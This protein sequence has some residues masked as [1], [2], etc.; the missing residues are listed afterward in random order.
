MK[1][2]TTILVFVFL[3]VSN[4]WAQ[5][6]MNGTFYI[7]AAGTKPGGGD[8]E[9]T[10][11]KA[12]V[13]ALNTNGV[14]GA[15]TFYFTSTD[16]TEPADITLG[17]AG[18]SSTNTVTFKPYT[19]VTGVKITFTTEGNTGAAGSIDG[20]F[21]IGSPTGVNTNLVP[22]NYVTIDGSNAADGTTKDLS[23]IGPATAI[24]KSV[25]RIF[26]NNDNITIK[27]C[28]ITCN[29]TSA[30]MAAALNVSNFAPSSA[31]DYLTVSNCTLNSTAGNGG[32]AMYL[33]NSGSPTVGAKGYVISNN[34]LN[35]RQRG[36]YIL[37]VSEGEISGN[38]F[39]INST[40]AAQSAVGLFFISTMADAGV[41][42]IYN[43]NF[44]SLTTQN[45]TA[46]NVNGIIGIDIQSQDPKVFNIYNNMISGLGTTAATA[47]AKLYGIRVTSMA[48]ANI[49]NNTIYIPEM[50]DMTLFGASFIA[51]ITYAALSEVAPKAGGAVNLK[52]NLIICDETV[53]KV[54]GIR[55]AGT[56]GTFTSNHN[57]IF[58]NPANTSSFTGHFNTTSHQT[59]DAW[60]AASLQDSASVAVAVNFVS[61]SDVHLA[62]SSIGDKNLT[63]VPVSFITKD[64]DGDLRNPLF[65]YMGADENTTAPLPVEL[66]SFS[67]ST[68]GLNVVL[69][70]KTATELNSQFFEPERRSG[71][72]AWVKAGRVSASGNSST[73]RIYTFADRLPAPGSYSYRLKM[74]DLDG[75]FSYSSVVNV[76]SGL[77]ENYSLSQNYPNPFNPSTTISYQLPQDG[78]V[79]LSVFDALGREVR[80]LVNTFQQ[81]G[82]HS[83]SVDAGSLT[84]GIYFYRLTVNNVTLTK[85]MQLM[86]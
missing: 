82:T 42:N 72:G 63:A 32:A 18:T 85:K 25:I 4:V 40:A 70:W 52:N 41:F 66:T 62:G 56:D 43:N 50:T 68:E 26:G 28:I 61:P 47:N 7:G 11:L 60:K 64:F 49:F 79:R 35:A 80:S 86:K 55:R 23:I 53:M 27:N 36:I 71:N 24:Q 45:T 31:P 12:A 21:V 44:A 17:C 9:Y 74:I 54:W 77:P 65:P 14:G 33:G 8:P 22:T 15:C 37:F 58:I 13:D 1:K 73:A 2:I 6:P 81:A 51:G 16:Y 59:L 78:L 67:C 69:T 5:A 34:I 75:S 83:V 3:A 30:S 29:S 39:N 46:S 10:S 38:T 48:T 84:S 76:A 19:G 20:S 57:D